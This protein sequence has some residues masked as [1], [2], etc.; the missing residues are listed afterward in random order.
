MN[1]LTVTYI[2]SHVAYGLTASVEEEVSGFGILGIN[3]LGEIRQDFYRVRHGTR[4]GE[5][6]GGDGYRNSGRL[7]IVN[8]VLCAAAFTWAF[9]C[10]SSESVFVYFNF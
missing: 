2:Y 6:F 7:G 9:L 8:M 4:H 5:G 3:S 1:D 10:L